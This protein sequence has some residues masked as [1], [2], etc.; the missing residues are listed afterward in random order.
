MTRK[1]FYS[2]FALR[3]AAAVK[4]AT[5][6]LFAVVVSGPLAQNLTAETTDGNEIVSEMDKRMNFSECKMTVR[7]RRQKN[8]TARR[9]R[10]GERRVLDR[11]GNA[12]WSSSNRRGTGQEVAQCRDRR[13]G[14][15]LPSVSKPVRL[16][17]KDAFRGTSFTNDDIEPRQVGRTTTLRSRALTIPAG[18]SR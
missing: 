10:S 9:A 12:A 6:A 4:I 14:W 16:S 18:T 1:T 3:T 15:P 2:I 17:G 7:N 11:R 8:P 13:C 5:M